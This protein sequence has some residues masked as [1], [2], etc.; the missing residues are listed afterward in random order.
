MFLWW[1]SS[2]RFSRLAVSSAYWSSSSSFARFS[3]GSRVHA[4]MPSSRSSLLKVNSCCVLSAA[5]SVNLDNTRCCYCCC[6]CSRSSSSKVSSV[7]VVVV[8]VVAS[9]SATT[10]C[11]YSPR[12]RRRQSSALLC[13]PD[14]I[15]MGRATAPSRFDD[16]PRGVV[17]ARSTIAG[18]RASFF[19]PPSLSATGDARMIRTRT[20]ARQLVDFGECLVD[21]RVLNSPFERKGHLGYIRRG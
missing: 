3:N 9:S 18:V 4:S 16:I 8:V 1:V 5:T 7:V 17:E 13:F 15:A 10:S 2:S 12:R 11:C 21:K 14:S 19:S 20:R 6:C